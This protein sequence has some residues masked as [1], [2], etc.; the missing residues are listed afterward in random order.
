MREIRES[1][2]KVKINH[3]IIGSKERFVTFHRPGEND[4]ALIMLNKDGRLDV[5]RSVMD[6]N[7]RDLFNKMSNKICDVPESHDRNDLDFSSYLN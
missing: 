3:L 7:G 6:E 4:V 1:K 5:M 2:R